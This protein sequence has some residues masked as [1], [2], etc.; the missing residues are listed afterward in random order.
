MWQEE[1]DDNSDQWILVDGSLAKEMNKST[2][3][4]ES[5]R[6]A[7]SHM[8]IETGVSTQDTTPLPGVEVDVANE[9]RC[10]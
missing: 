4:L 5:L 6:M 8:E 7:N 3:R 2:H 10:Y 9:A 1:V